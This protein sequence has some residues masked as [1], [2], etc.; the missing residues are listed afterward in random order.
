[1]K[2]C[3][4]FWFLLPI[5]TTRRKA[6]SCPQLPLVAV[7]SEQYFQAPSFYDSRNNPVKNC[8][9]KLSPRPDKFSHTALRKP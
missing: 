3:F 4:G 2:I 7:N 8:E 9:R 1:M 5:R 6:P